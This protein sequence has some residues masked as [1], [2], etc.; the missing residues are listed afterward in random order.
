MIKL[1]IVAFLFFL[2]LNITTGAIVGGIK[3]FFTLNNAADKIGHDIGR[4]SAMALVHLC[5]KIFGRK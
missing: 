5:E 4:R 3:G 1:F 2:W